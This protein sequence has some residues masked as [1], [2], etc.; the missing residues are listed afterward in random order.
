MVCRVQDGGEKSEVCQAS[1]AVLIDQDVE[2]DK[3]HFRR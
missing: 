2:L 3:K 1:T